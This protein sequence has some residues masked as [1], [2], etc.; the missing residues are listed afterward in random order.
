MVVFDIP[1]YSHAMDSY[2]AT[3]KKPLAELEIS[4]IGVSANP[5]GDQLEGLKAKIFQGASRVELGFAGAGKGS[6]QG[7]QTTPGMYGADERQDIRELAQLNEVKLSTHASY[8][9]GPLSGMARGGFDESQREHTLHEIQRAIDFASDTAKGGAVVVHAGEFPRAISEDFGSQGFKGFQNEPNEA[10]MY[11]VDKQNGKI[12]EGVRKDQ[13]VFWPV[14]EKNEKGNYVKDEWG[15]FVPEWDKANKTF[16]VEQQTWEDFE[17]FAKWHNEHEATNGEKI[18][19]AQAFYRASLE[20][21]R[22]YAYAWGIQHAH[23]FEEVQEEL[24]KYKKAL[25]FYQN[26]E[27]NIPEDEKWKLLHEG[28]RR[29]VADIFVPADVKMPSEW[30]QKQIKDLEV[31]AKYAKEVSVSQLQQ[32]MEMKDMGERAVPIQDYAL[33]R[34]ADTIARA[35]EFALGK[36]ETLKKRG[37]LKEPIFVAVENIEPEMYGSHPEELK[38]LIG[39]ARDEFVKRNKGK[40]GEDKARE[41]AQDYIKATFDIGHANMWRKYFEGDPNKS[42]EENTSTFQN[43]LLNQVQDLNK[44]KMIGHVHVSDNFGWNDEHVTPG[45]GTAPIK[46]FVDKMKKAGMQDLIVEPG[47]QDFKAMLGGWREFGAP[48]YGSPPT[49]RWENIEHSYFGR[50]RRPYFI[51]GDYAPSQ[52]FTLWTGVGLE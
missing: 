8:A 1:T 21:K 2:T 29:Y 6:M 9:A 40:Y 52:D 7:R 28:G 22:Q 43:W 5:T 24:G 20:A 44:N 51:F 45:Q 49:E 26:L 12:I 35:A 47:H 10:V 39:N 16:K 41:L 50:V 30:L 11:L 48:I 37:E 19:P 42:W 23:Q 46:E 25:E 17:K 31:S 33:E 4:Q 27:K 13:K 34:S 14:W 3:D 38:A 18:T 36:S 32:S 15:Q